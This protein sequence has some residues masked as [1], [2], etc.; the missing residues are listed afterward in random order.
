MRE[1]WRAEYAD[2]D[3]VELEDIGGGNGGGTV[4]P[5]AALSDKGGLGYW[6][7]TDK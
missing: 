2:L 3:F 5:F 1:M 7:S 6:G 4:R